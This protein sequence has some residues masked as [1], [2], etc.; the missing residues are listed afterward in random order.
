V[1]SFILIVS[2]LAFA[3]SVGAQGL[4]LEKGQSGS[5]GEAGYAYGEKVGG[6]GG[7]AFGAILGGVADI[8]ATISVSQDTRSLAQCLTV[9]AVR[10]TNASG[11]GLIFSLDQ[12]FG[13]QRR[14]PFALLGGSVSAIGPVSLG[15]MLV[16]TTGVHHLEPLDQ[17][18]E[19]INSYAIHLSFAFKTGRR[20]LAVTPSLSYSEG[21]TA[22]GITLGYSVYK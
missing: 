16:I 7:V 3:S 5:F 21:L 10:L 19:G 15:R 18:G 8:G 14:E 13:M 22:Y 11:S 20:M 1:K 6:S 9:Y 17:G 4:F 2:L 12:S